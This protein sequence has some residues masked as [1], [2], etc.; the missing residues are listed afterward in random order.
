MGYYIEVPKDKGKA[1]QIVELYGGRIV[2][3]PHRS[4]T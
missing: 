1:Q 4:R 2:F 3:S